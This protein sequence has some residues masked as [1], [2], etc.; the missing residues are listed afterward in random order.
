M[1]GRCPYVCTNKTAEGYCKTT[2]C[3]NPSYMYVLSRNKNTSRM[4]ACIA[5]STPIMAGVE[6]AIVHWE[7]RRFIESAGET[8]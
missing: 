4:H 3:I 1:T 6:Y 2:G 7:Y 5:H 8:E